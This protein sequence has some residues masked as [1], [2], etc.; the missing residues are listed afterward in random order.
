M[1]A[2]VLQQAFFRE[3]DKLRHSAKRIQPLDTAEMARKVG[4]L[5][6][7]AVLYIQKYGSYGRQG[8]GDMF[9]ALATFLCFLCEQGKVNRVLEYTTVPS[10]LTARL[11]EGHKVK[12]VSYVAPYEQVVQ[13]LQVL[14]D[15]TAASIV[16][17]TTELKKDAGFD[18]IICVPPLGHRPEGQSQADGFGGEVVRQLV[19]VLAKGG[20]LYW[21]T[22]RGAVFNPRGEETLADLRNDG[23]SAVATIDV[24]PGSFLGTT[25]EGVVIALR[26][27]APAKRF[28]GALRDIETAEPM[29]SA[30]LGGPS[31]KAGASWAWLDT[32]DQR[33]FGDLEDA[34]LLQ[35]LAPRGR[36][37]SVSLASLLMG[38]NV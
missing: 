32:E 17:N 33:T 25:I 14:F 16:R 10:V 4:L 2:E 5:P 19:P 8:S 34:R 6:H 3:M 36:H 22:G 28:V 35:K 15:D 26:R 37:T 13:V 29:A 38:D 18:A 7:E 24:A 12:N 31:R 9:D 27:D 1:S 20:T 30:F 23:L 21:V 11:A